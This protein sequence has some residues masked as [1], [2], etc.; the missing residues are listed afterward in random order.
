MP[1]VQPEPAGWDVILLTTGTKKCS[2]VLTIG[3]EVPQKY[4]VS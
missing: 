3:W 2:I 4:V 1:V